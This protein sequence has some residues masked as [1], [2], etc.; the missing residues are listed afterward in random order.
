MYEISLFSSQRM[1][2][3]R[4]V[5]AQVVSVRRIER[6]S[7]DDRDKQPS[8]PDLTLASCPCRHA[9]SG[10]GMRLILDSQGPSC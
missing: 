8:C 6:C 10:R 1:R 9:L 7:W 2:M 4:K 5:H 3:R